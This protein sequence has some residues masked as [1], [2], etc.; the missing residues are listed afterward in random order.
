MSAGNNI[1][2]MKNDIGIYQRL[3]TLSVKGQYSLMVTAEEVNRICALTYTVVFKLWEKFKR[4][5]SPAKIN[6][7]QYDNQK[8]WTELSYGWEKYYER[9]G[10]KDSFADDQIKEIGILLFIFSFIDYIS[11]EGC[12]MDW[13]NCN[14]NDIKIK[15][16][17]HPKISNDNKVTKNFKNCLLLY[18]Y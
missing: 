2:P 9:I 5:T 15:W 6:H 12:R 7:G 11:A 3:W 16:M 1:C 13:P 17:T 10:L 4:L 18:K 8:R 14:K